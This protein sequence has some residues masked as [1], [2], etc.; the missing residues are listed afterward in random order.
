MSGLAV[1]AKRLAPG[2]VLAILLTAAPAIAADSC[3]K[4]GSVRA[5]PR[6]SLRVARPEI[7]NDLPL[8]VMK[9]RKGRGEAILMGK[10]HVEK[11]YRFETRFKVYKAP[12]GRGVCVALDQV[13][14]KVELT[15]IT[16]YIAERSKPGSCEYKVTLRHEEK[17]LRYEREAMEAELR[18]LE[19]RIRASRK[20]FP[21]GSEK[22]AKQRAEQ[23]IADWVE[24]ALKNAAAAAERNHNRLDS[25]N[26]AKR[27]ADRCK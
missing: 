2:L 27:E 11:Q 12:N 19:G 15:P 9:A 24:K 23:L 7:K 3:T 21:A 13:E 8:T 26:N 18:K 4:L 6:T 5:T 17:H 20:P 10:I 1:Q 16:I 14:V 22:D 25:I